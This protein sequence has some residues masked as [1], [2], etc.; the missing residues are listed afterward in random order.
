MSGQDLCDGERR[1]LGWDASHPE[2]LYQSHKC[3]LCGACVRIAEDAGQRP[4]LTYVGRGFTARIS[5]PYE[6]RLADALGPAAGDCADACPTS[7]LR[8]KGE[9]ERGP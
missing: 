4:G 8:R 7:A 2:V 5:A 1:P 9:H 6:G 3:I